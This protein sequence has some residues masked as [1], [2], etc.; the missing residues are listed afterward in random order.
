MV[1]YKIHNK[2]N[3][4]DLTYPSVGLWNSPDITEARN[5][6]DALKGYLEAIG[7]GF[8]SKDV[9]IINMETGEEIL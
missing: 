1:S 2:S 9:V 8:I 5:H 4:H 6:I 7:M 3:G